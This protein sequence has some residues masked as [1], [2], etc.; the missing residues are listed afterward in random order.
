MIGYL[1]LFIALTLYYTSHRKWSILLFVIFAMEGL[2]LLPNELLGSKFL[3]LAFLYMIIIGTYSAIY[4]RDVNFYLPHLRSTVWMLIIF[5]ISS[6]VFSLIYYKFTP[7]QIFQGGRHLFLFASYF[8]LRKVKKEDIEW[9]FKALL[10]ITVVHAGLYIVQCLTHLPVLGVSAT[11]AFN[12]RAGIFRYYNY[13]QLMPFFLLLGLLFPQLLSKRTLQISILLFIISIFLTQGRTYIIMNIFVC[14]IGLM[15]RGK[16]TR[17]AQWAII[18]GIV[19]LPL[20][21][22]V[23]SRFNEEETSSDISEIL[24][25]NFINYANSGVS[26]QGNLTFRFAW[27]AERIIYLKGRPIGEKFYGLGMISDSQNIVNNKYQFIIGLKNSNKEVTQLYTGDI[28]W[29]NFVT[30][31][32]G[33]G[34]ILILLLWCALFGYLF[35]LR[36]I[37]PLLMCGTLFL[38]FQFLNSIADSH[39]S[40]TGNMAFSFLLCTFGLFAYMDNYE[41]DEAENEENIDGACIC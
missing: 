41:I 37:H 5:L 3:D 13:P 40:N 28:A 38:L 19:A 22:S 9:I 30:Q 31:F 16:L 33:G 6:A 39:M 23:I 12:E 29:G 24:S 15:M 20:V 7:F 17:L 21:D 4:E 26:D 18:G 2:R 27:L 14:L 35:K 25:G 8:F 32:G 10:Y 36:H 1:L 34:T 11:E